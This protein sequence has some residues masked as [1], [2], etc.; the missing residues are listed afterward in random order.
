MSL[1]YKKYLKYK[2]K[3]VA[4]KNKIWGGKIVSHKT[5][6]EDYIIDNYTKKPHYLNHIIL[7]L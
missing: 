6:F 4:L 1:Y 2:E 3:Y 7:F 5:H